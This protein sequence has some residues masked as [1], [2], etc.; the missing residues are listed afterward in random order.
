MATVS[1]TKIQLRR[2]RSSDLQTADLDEGELGYTTDTG[3]LFVGVGNDVGMPNYQRASFPYQNIEVLTENSP[4][5]A[6]LG[7]VVSDNQS[8]FIQSAALG[9]SSTFQYNL[10]VGITDFHLEIGVGVNAIVFYFVFDAQG[11]PIRQGQLKVLWNVMMTSPPLCVDDAQGD[12]NI[13]WQAVLTGSL[14]HQHIV[15]Q[16]INQ[17]GGNPVVLFRVDRPIFVSP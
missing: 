14:G 16:Y 13:Q 8:G 4:L 6:I 10:Q 3:R 11:N 17:T 9:Q 2:G 1:I 7:A 12:L 5:Q 15:L